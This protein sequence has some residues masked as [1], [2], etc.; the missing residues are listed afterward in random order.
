M[1]DCSLSTTRPPCSLLYFLNP[2]QGDERARIR[3]NLHLSCFCSPPP[4]RAFR[5][6]R[7]RYW[8]ATVGHHSGTNRV[9]PRQVFNFSS[10]YQHT[11]E[12][13]PN[14]LP[15]TNASCLPQSGKCCYASDSSMNLCRYDKCMTRECMLCWINASLLVV[16]SRE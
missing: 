6:R 2:Q 3:R 4:S 1:H 11:C 15:E 13:R 9:G 10:D 8:E 7:L 14:P 12:I 5:R 16:T